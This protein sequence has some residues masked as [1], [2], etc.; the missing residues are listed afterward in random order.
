[1]NY[2]F[3]GK[4]PCPVC[5]TAPDRATLF[6]DANY[7]APKINAFGFACRKPPEYMCHRFVRC[8]EALDRVKV[9][10]NV[11]NTL[12]FGFKPAAQPASS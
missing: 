10:F 12:A 5:G 6:L 7:D 8:G 4:R 3:G 9:R 2:T 11:D 1:M